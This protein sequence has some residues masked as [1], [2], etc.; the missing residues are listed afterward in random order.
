MR[1]NSVTDHDWL[2]DLFEEFERRLSTTN[3]AQMTCVLSFTEADHLDLDSMW[4]VLFSR[5]DA[6]F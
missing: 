4:N 2:G 6:S 1:F 5:E 3:P